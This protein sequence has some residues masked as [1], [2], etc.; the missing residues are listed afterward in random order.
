MSQIALTI[1]DEMMAIREWLR[2]LF[3][4]IP[5]ENF[6]LEQVPEQPM[7]DSFV[8]RF[9]NDSREYVTPNSFVSRREYQVIHFNRIPQV[10]SRMDT[11]SRQCLHGRMLIPISEESRRY[12]RVDSFSFGNTL[13]LDNTDDIKAIVGVLVVESREARN[14]EHFEKIKQISA[15]YQIKIPIGG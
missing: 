4:D 9:Q 8:L 12:I 5:D 10:L 3:P 13:D 7:A 6:G 15:R 14:A 11:I 2:G 1:V